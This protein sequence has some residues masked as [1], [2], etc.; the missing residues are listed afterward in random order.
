MSLGATHGEK[1]GTRL[2]SGV[3]AMEETPQ[4]STR[5]AR[6]GKK[7]LR[8]SVLGGAIAIFLLLIVA[9]ILLRL[10]FGL[11]S[12]LLY[13]Q[14][15]AC[16]YL[17]KPDQK[18]YRFFAHNQINHWGMR[19]ANFAMPRPVGTF[20]VLMIGDSVT[21]G[22]TF[23]DQPLIFTSLLNTSLSSLEHT[24]VEV[25][26]A[27]AGGWAPANEVSYLLSRGT[28]DA[29]VV[30]LVLNA[31]DPTQEF[32]SLTEPDRNF[33][34][35]APWSALGE[36]WSRYV[37]PRLLGE[38]IS[39]DPGTTLPGFKLAALRIEANLRV[40]EQARGFCRRSEAVF[41]LVYIP[42][43]GWHEPLNTGAHQVLADWVGTNHVPFIDLGPKFEHEDDKL[44]TFDGMHLRPYGDQVAAD[45]IKRQ[46]GVIDAALA[47]T[48]SQPATSKNGAIPL[49]R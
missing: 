16:G 4:T 2:T 18:I 23:V 39:N 36:T 6:D 45:E 10:V 49:V 40:L 48:E 47:A 14:D 7:S 42:F 44:L 3:H 24:N 35:Q 46:W 30:L 28:F 37:K 9:E 41:G 22:N 26:N 43:A 5:P 33:P 20:R 13:Q 27:S 12:P 31:G 1:Q 32:A 34:L 29:N 8:R 25:L 15:P 38:P 21:Y 19:S 11:G 17:P